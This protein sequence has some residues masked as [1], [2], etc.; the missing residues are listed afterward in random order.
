MC[1]IR[2]KYITGAREEGERIFFSRETENIVTLLDFD[3]C[4][5]YWYYLRYL[6][7]NYNALHECM[8]LRA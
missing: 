8:H 7:Y 5:F 6:N 3:V 4:S 1:E 2:F